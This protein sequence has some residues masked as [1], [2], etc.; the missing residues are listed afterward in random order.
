MLNDRIALSSKEILEKE[1]KIDARGYRLQ[2]VDKF[3]DVVIHDYNEYNS[4]IK[5]L[6]IK[7]N[8]LHEE[9]ENLKSE[10][11]NLKSDLEALKYTEKEVTNV[12]L[13]R[14]VSQLEKIILGD[15]N[16]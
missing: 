16:N 3:L 4:I 15:A 2:E 5:E 12:D 9:N 8:Q 14:R 13:I 11:R 7:N 10:V 6:A 1:F